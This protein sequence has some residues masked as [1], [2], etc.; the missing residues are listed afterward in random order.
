MT[1]E[2][3]EPVKYFKLESKENTE[4]KISALAA[5]Q[6][7]LLSKMVKHLDLSADYE[8]ME[9]IPITNI[10]EKTLVKVIEW[11]EKHKEDPMLEDRLP[12]PP[13]VVIPDWDQEFLQID[14]VELFDLIVAVNYL[15]IQRLM[16]YACKK[17]ALM[18]KGK[19][20]E[21][22]RVIFGIPTDEED[23]EMERAAAEKIKA[24][25]EAAAVNSH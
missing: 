22:L 10:S 18:G 24:E 6:S 9:P 21:E 1:D 23:A 7:G 2:P 3:M 11:C 12:D 16:N 14:N 19:S 15:N 8:N 25:R 4:L 20:P 5:E 17:V 13:V